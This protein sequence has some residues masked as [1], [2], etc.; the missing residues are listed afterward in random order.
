[1]RQHGGEGGFAHAAFAAEDQDFV[2]DAGEAGGYEGDVGVGTF[3][4]GGADGLVGAA[5]AGIAFAG[6]VGFGAGAVFCKN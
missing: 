5:G 6:K 3:G 2:L 1:M 4:S